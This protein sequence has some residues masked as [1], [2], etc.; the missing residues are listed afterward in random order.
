MPGIA[1][2]PSEIAPGQVSDEM[3]ISLDLMATMLDFAG[4]EQPKGHAL[5]GVS[6]RPVLLGSGSLGQRQF[7]WRG[8][9]MR[10]GQWKYV[11]SP[12]GGGLFNLKTDLA[13]SMNLAKRHPGRIAIRVGYDTALAHRIEAGC[14]FFVMPSRFEPCGLNQLYSLRYGAVPVV[15][16]TGGLEDSIIDLGE[17]DKMAT[18]IKFDEPSAAALGQALGRAFSLYADPARL[19]KVRDN[20]MRADFSW[21]RTTTKY[22]RLY[23]TIRP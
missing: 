16:A 10:D 3:V 21:F 2:W 19:A 14:D 11:A 12:K 7:F 17:G 20:G 8:Q 18:G 15:R 1:W 6:L 22:D 23:N 9:A 4:A 13:E 5:D